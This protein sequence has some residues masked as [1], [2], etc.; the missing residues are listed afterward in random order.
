MHLH[1]PCTL[2]FPGFSYTHFT[3]LCH[4]PWVGKFF[5]LGKTLSV[6]PRGLQG[7]G[8]KGG[9]GVLGYPCL[10]TDTLLSV[11]HHK[12]W[13]F[14]TMLPH[15]SCYHFW[16]A[17]AQEHLPTHCCFPPPTVSPKGMQSRVG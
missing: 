11:R 16:S 7:L 2:F 15:P 8:P 14:I 12:Y 1:T 10:H 6:V 13:T 4:G 3:S 9:I 17:S 5:F